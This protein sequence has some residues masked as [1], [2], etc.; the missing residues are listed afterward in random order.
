MPYFA[1]V[2]RGVY[3]EIGPRQN[4]QTLKYLTGDRKKLQFITMLTAILRCY[5]HR[6]QQK[7]KK[8]LHRALFHNVNVLLSN[9]TFI[10]FAVFDVCINAGSPLTL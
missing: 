2:R 8:L 5:T 4:K 10:I 7:S 1:I 3:E 9:I 6:K